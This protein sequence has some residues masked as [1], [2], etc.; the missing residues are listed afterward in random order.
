M[1][2]LLLVVIC[3]YLFSACSIF[4]KNTKYGCGTDGRN[5]GAEKLLSG[6]PAS[7]KAAKKA[8]WRGERTTY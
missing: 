7:M 6:D 8:K 3:A 1:K 5:I 4:R 2:K